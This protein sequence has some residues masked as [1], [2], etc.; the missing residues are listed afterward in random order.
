MAGAYVG[1][2]GEGASW[3]PWAMATGTPLLMVALM[4]LGMARDDRPLGWLWGV[5]TFKL[6]ACVGGFGLG[7]VLPPEAPGARLVL[8]L[9][10]RAAAVLYGVGFLP[11]FVLPVAYALSFDRLTLTEDDLARVRAAAADVAASRRE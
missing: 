7:L 4:V 2:F 6:A 10:V 1:A 9:P 3:A 8:G 11:L 5:L